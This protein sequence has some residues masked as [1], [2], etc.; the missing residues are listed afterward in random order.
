MAEAALSRREATAADAAAAAAAELDAARRAAAAAAAAAA[1]ELDGRAERL[2][3]AERAAEERAAASLRDLGAQV[4]ASAGV[5]MGVSPQ[6][7][8]WLPA[9]LGPGA[10]RSREAPCAAH[11]ERMCRPGDGRRRCCLQ[12]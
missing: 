6:S 12:A 4:P 3:A 9:C 2:A 11:R 8:G 10:L 7:V 5:G 1:A